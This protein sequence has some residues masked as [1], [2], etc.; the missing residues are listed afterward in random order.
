MDKFVRRKRGDQ[1]EPEDNSSTAKKPSKTRKY[2]TGYLKYGF[3]VAKTTHN[4]GE[5][6]ILPATKAI[7][8]EL[9][10]DD[11]AKKIDTVPLSDNSVSRRIIDMAE[12]VSVQLLEQ[13]RANGVKHSGVTALIKQKAPNAVS[14]HCVLHREA[15]VAKRLDDELNEVLQ[16][17]IQVVDFIKARPLK[18]R[19]FARLCNE[20]GARYEGLLLHSN[21][22]WLSRGAV[23]NRVYEMRSEIAE[24]L[25][26]E[27]HQLA[28]RFTNAEWIRKLTYMSDIFHHLNQLNQSMQGRDTYVLHVQDKVRAFSKKI[29]LWSNKLQEG[30]SEM[31]P[32]LHQELLSS[33]ELGTISPLIQSHLKHL[34]GY[35]RDYFPDLENTHLNWIRDPFAPDVG[36]SLDVKSQEELIEMS[37]ELKMKFGTIPL[38]HYWIYVRKD[39][40]ALAE[41]ALKCLLPFA[42]TYLCESG[43]S[44]LKVLKTKHR[45]CLQVDN[46]MRMALTAIKPRFNK[47]CRSHQAHPAH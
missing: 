35:F 17:A 40:P 22:R 21:V 19:L 18:H 12:D 24:F 28:E 41:R 2:E 33:G 25:S 9:L 6:L 39:Y 47:L 10:G 26:S 8:R 44:T 32:L 38:S 3:T 30:V 46:D 36:N 15:L 29:T 23:L 34:Q 13:V 4:R 1:E 45:A 14:T 37:C 27:K 31:F 42:T 7:V 43:F 16:D 5:D 20:M 11:A